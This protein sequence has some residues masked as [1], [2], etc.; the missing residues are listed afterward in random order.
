MLKVTKTQTGPEP[1]QLAVAKPYL[2]VTHEFD[3]VLINNII[4]EARKE[5]EQKTNLSLVDS[6]IELLLSNYRNS[7]TL[8]YRPINTVSVCELDGADIID[9]VVDGEIVR[10][11]RGRLQV[12]YTTLAYP[13]SQLVMMEMTTFLYNNR[14][15]AGLGYSV[16]P[17][18]VKQWIANNTMNLW[19]Q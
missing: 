18:M 11:G 14:G 5:L 10:R 16:F 6:D 8:P 19:L 9:S 2:R 15:S 17:E 12:E 4:K 13:V 1:L 3:D 7:F